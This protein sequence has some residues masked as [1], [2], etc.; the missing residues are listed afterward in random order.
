MGTAPQG[1]R[2]SPAADLRIAVV[3]HTNTGK[4]SLLR[5]LLRDPSFGEVSDAPATTRHVEGA[6]LPVDGAGTV[7][8]YDTPG[9]ED[10][11]GLLDTLER[12][13]LADE[14]APARLQRFLDDESARTRFEQEAKALR[15]VLASDV[16]LYVI[17]AR[18]PVLGKYRD[19]LAIL[20]GSAR[21]VI[22]VLNFTAAP[23]AR[24][25]AWREQLARLNLHAVVSCDAVV[26]DAAGELR[27]FEKLGSLL[28]ARHG[29]LDALIRQRRDEGAWLRRAA[30]ELIADLLI[31][32]AACVQ[33]VPRDPG[34]GD[35]AALEALRAAVRAREQRC[36]EEL[37]ALFRF[38]PGDW[39]EAPLPLVD[40]HW[41]LDLFSARAL[42]H[43]GI[44]TGGA[45]ATGAAAGF[46]IDAV[47]GMMS[48]GAA[49]LL[50]A[51]AGTVVGV[52]R[53]LGG[54]ALAAL[55]GRVE[56]RVHDAPLR[57]LMARERE[58][59]G[60]LLRRGHASVTPI[61]MPVR[62]A[63]PTLPEALRAARNHR[64]WSRLNAPAFAPDPQRQRA[65]E[66]V[67]GALLQTL[68]N[69]PR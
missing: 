33:V 3:G 66:T 9:L 63:Q 61:D 1:T 62:G 42:R 12:L 58:L 64:H 28:D 31:D 7:V 10:P 46:G 22:P 57:L 35:A 69:A 34:G 18:E 39:S 45:A 8:L 68:G 27:L 19:E 4:T 15:Q 16:V 26:F 38:R 67:A 17:D 49:T 20:A 13:A 2:A 36:V 47:T 59:L 54:R 30:A 25:D 6:A 23:D 65:L 5:T 50:G 48:L 29:L 40:G 44:R 55:R 14:D 60:A 53:D 41:G 56:L 52:A 32:V 21:P 37:L 43:H 24:A 51:A 11:G